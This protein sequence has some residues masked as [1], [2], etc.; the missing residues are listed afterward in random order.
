MRSIHVLP[1]PPGRCE[2]NTRYLPS[3][4]QRGFELSA[5]GDVN[6]SGSPHPLGALCGVPGHAVATTH[7]SRWYLLSFSLTV[8][9][10]NAM[11]LPS[12]DIAGELNVVSLYQSLSA[13]GRFAC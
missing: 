5:L 10:W 4:D 1:F 8:C 6:R 2:V 7:T 9:T 12:G 3:G 13:K 11:R